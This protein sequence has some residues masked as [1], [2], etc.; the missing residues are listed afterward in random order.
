MIQFKLE[1]ITEEYL[2]SLT[3]N[4]VAEG[5]TIEYKEKLP[6]NTD[7]DKK[8]FL[9][10]LSS[11]A[12]TSGGDL[13]YGIE[14]RK[15]LPVAVAGVEIENPDAELNRLENIAMNGIDPR[16]S[17]ALRAIK[18]GSGKF[19]V[20]GRVRQSWVKPHRVIF[21][22][23]DKFYGR[24]SI[25]KY[26]LDVAELR[27][28]FNL[29]DTI[30]KRIQDFRY[31]RI[32]EIEADKAPLPVIGANKII[33]HLIPLESF[34]TKMAIDSEKLLE[35]RKHPEGLRPMSAS[36]WHAPTVNLHGI[37]SH[38]G[39]NEGEAHSYVQIFRNGV[40]EIVESSILERD[41]SKRIPSYTIEDEILKSTTRYLNL[42]KSLDLNPP[43]YVFISL[44][45]VKGL[46]M[47][48]DS[49]KYNYDANH[50]REESIYLPEAVIDNYDQE[51]TSTL[52]PVF[53]L[54]WNACGIPRSLN[55]DNDGNW[56]R[57]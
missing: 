28:I 54:V 57:R 48:F 20:V 29:S 45:H 1:E 27:D 53:D 18:L 19:V 43:I 22:G 56:I 49:F 21:G 5:K 52:R 46:I 17:Y 13:L 55:F 14:E 36:G 41:E 16:I 3:K 47:S 33:L 50:I 35:L 40:I 6:G 7:S 8:E 37:V 34:S 51:L 24:N 25:G 15:G 23:H 9:A 38:A 42:L 32:M 4:S 31:S 10:D 11:F 26:P 39:R 44:M 30:A 12:N 2:N